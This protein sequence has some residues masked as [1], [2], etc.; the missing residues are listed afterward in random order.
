MVLEVL[1]LFCSPAGKESAY[2]V[3]DLGL[4]PGLI[5]E[6]QPRRSPGEGRDYPLQY[7]GLENSMDSIAHGVTKSLTRLSNSLHFTSKYW[8]SYNNKFF[9]RPLEVPR[10]KPLLG[11][12]K[13]T[14]SFY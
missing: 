10:P 2:N 12:E 8:A 7:S 1:G 3:G 13:I 14:L 4:I 11:S 9:K 6:D 5:K